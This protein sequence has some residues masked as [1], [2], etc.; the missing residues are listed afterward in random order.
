ML[1]SFGDQLYISSNIITSSLDIQA[2]PQRPQS[3]IPFEYPGSLA[4]NRKSLIVS[5][6]QPVQSLVQI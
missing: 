1:S 5:E 2:G 6:T 4:W 3:P